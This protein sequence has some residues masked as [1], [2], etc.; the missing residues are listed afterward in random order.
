MQSCIQRFR[1]RRRLQGDRGLY[2]NEYL[3]LGGVDTSPNTFGGLSQQE[4][5]DLTPAQRR[6]ATAT[7]II[8]A[9]SQGGDRFVSSSGKTSAYFVNHPGS[10]SLGLPSV[11]RFSWTRTRD[12]DSISVVAGKAFK[13][14]GI[15]RVQVMALAISRTRVKQKWGH[16]GFIVFMRDGR[17]LNT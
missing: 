5:K 11:E 1:S 10:P 6:E 8:W 14:D 17:V 12:N 13:G 9:N 16:I 4:L 7:D 15:A 2:F 3:F